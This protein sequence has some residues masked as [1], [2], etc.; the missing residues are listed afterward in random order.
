MKKP[1]TLK[2]VLAVLLC[3]Q[4]FVIHA[5]KDFTPRFDTSLK[6]DML[7]IGNNIL[8]RDNNKANE[9]PND[10]Y[11]VY[12]QNNNNLQMYYVDID[13][14]SSTFSSSSATLS[15]PS[16]SRE[17]YKIV[18]AGLYWAG[19]YSQGSIDN[20][21]VNRSNLGSIKI[22]LPNQ[23]AYTDISGQ[24]IYDY[25]PSNSNGSQI[26]YAYYYDLTSLVQG[27]ANPEGQYTVANIISAQGNINGGFSAGWNLFVVYEDPKSSAKYI[28]SFDGFRWIQANSNAVT[29]NISGFKTIPTGTVKAKLAFAALEGDVDLTGDR[30][31]INNTDIS[32]AERPVDNFFNSTIND[33][34]GPFTNRNLASGNTLGFEAGILNVPNPANRQNPGGS[35]IKNNDTSATL[36]LTTSGDGYGLFFNAFNVEI[37]EPKIVLTKIVKN[38]QGVNIGGQNVTLGQQLNYEIGFKNT[39]NDNA[40]SFTIRDQLP[41]NIIFNYPAD[42]VSLPSGVTVQSYNAATRNIVFKVDNNVVKVG[43][44]EK[45]ISFKVQVVPDCHM[46]SEACSNSIDNSAYAT[47][48]GTQNTAF[49]ISDDPSVNTNTGC[50]LIP[51]AT[52]FLVGVDGCKYTDNVTLCGESINLTAANGYTDYTWYS[53]EARTQLIGKGQTLNVK[54]P[55]TY[56]VYNLAAAPCRS[57]YQ[58]FVVT[59]F[60]STVENPVIPFADQVV[61]CSND[62][63]KLPNIFLCGG[64]ASRA[65]TLNISDANSIVWEKLNESSCTAVTNQ[66]CANESTS[67]TWTT[68]KTGSTYNANQAGQFRL[69]LNYAG[70]CFNRFYFNVYSNSLT[71]TETHKDIICGAPGSITIGGVP[72]GYEYAISTDPNGTPGAY[73][74]SNIFPI[75]SPNSYTVHIRQIG[76]TT[77]PCIFTVPGILIR[78]RDLS[79][80]TTVTQP[81][82]KNDK[83]SIKVGAQNIDPQ[84]YY[85][86][87]TSG[88]TL[89][90]SFGPTLNSDYTFA[91]LSSGD[92]RV[93]VTNGAVGSTPAPSCDKTVDVTIN[94]VPAGLNPTAALT[95]PLTAC[96]NGKIVV[97]TTGGTA[98]YYHFINGSS[99]FQLSN[100]I[101]VTGPGTYDIR[102]VDAN[103]CSGTTSITVN[104]NPKPTYTVTAT[105]INCSG[106]TSQINV[107]VTNANGYTLQYSIDNGAT[108]SNNPVFPNVTAGTYNVVVRY[109]MSGVTCTDPATPIT[110]TQP[111]NALSASA[112]VSELAGC[113]PSG[114]GF[115]KVRITNPQGGT[116]PYTYSFDGGANY[117]T[118]NEAYV[119]PGTYTLYIKDSKGCIYSMPGVILDPK[120]A[121]PTISIAPPVFNCNGTATS[122]VTVTSGGGTNYAYQY[123]LDNVLNTNTPSNVFVNVPSGSHTISVKYNLTS[124]PTY[125]NLLIEDFGSGG[126]TTAP[127]IASAYCFNDQRV[128]PPYTCSLNGTPTRSVEDN[129]YSVTSFFWRNDT[130]WYHFKDHTS[131][132]A[133]ANGRYLLV[134]IGSAAGP[135]GILYSKPIIDVIPN[136]P[137]MVDL[138]VANLLNTGVSGAAPIVRFELV[139][140]AGQVVA[141]QDTGKIAEAANDPNRTKWVPINISLNPGNNTN[142]TFRIRSGSTD[143]AGN[144]I[145]IDDIWVRQIPKSCITQKDFPIVIDSNKAFSASITGFKNLTCAGSNNGEITIATQNFNLPYGFDYSLDNGTTW[146]NSKVSPVTA[147]GLTNKTYSI[148][149]R[150]DSSASSCTFPFSQVITAPAA[151][152]V[153]ARVTAQP[154][155]S[156]GASITATVTG[157]TPSYQYELRGSNGTTVVVPFQASNVFTNVATG[158]Y[159][160]VVKDTNACTSPASATVNISSPTV[161]TAT[162]AASSDLCYD[163]TNQSTLVVTATGTGTLTYS[164]DGGAAQTSNTFTNVGPG[165]HNVVVTDSNNCTATVSNIVIAPELQATAA[166]TKVVDCTSS[167]NA[168]I[169]VTITGGTSAF[170]YKVKRTGNYGSSNNVT[171]NSFVYTATNTGTYTFEI[172]DSKG[173][174]TTTSAT[175]NAR[176]NPTVTATKVDATCNGASTGSVELTGSGGSG[177]YTYLFYNSTTTPVPTTYT[178]QT[179]YTGLAAGTYNYRVMDSGT[180]TSA[181]GSITINQPTTLTATASATAFSC[182]TSNVK[183]SAT[184]T[185][186]VP[187]TGTSPYQYSFD[188]GT[189]FTSTRTLTVT[190]NGTNQTISYVVSDAQGCKTP[191]QTITINRLNPPTD[192]TFSSNAVTCTATTTTVTAT[193]TNGVGTLTYAITSPAASVAT[194]TTGV[195]SG[196]AAGTYNFRVTDANGCYFEKPYTINAV[197]PIAVIGN[198]T[199]DALC[200][201]GATG[202]GTYT[203]SGNAAVGAYTFTLTAGTLG[204]G[205]LTK[206]GNTLTLS[207]V[208]AGTYTVQVTDTA[209][210][211]TNTASIVI[212]EPANA[213]TFT[214]AASNV[215]CNND[216]SQITV[217]A[218]GG[219]P[220][221]TYAAVKSGAAAPTVYDASNVV[222]VDTNSGA[223]LVWDVYVKDT[224]GCIA[225]N[226]VTVAQDNLPTVTA[227]N[228]NQC[229]ASGNSF[230]ITATG[231]GLAPLM[232]SIDG[233]SFQSSNTFN[234]PAGTYT[235]TVRDKNNC[236][237][238]TATALTIYPQLTAVG[239]VTKELDCTT[240]PNATITVT[241]G[242]GKSQFTYTVQK[243]SGAPSTA[244]APISGPT[245]TY[246]VTPAN[247]DTYT[248]VVTDANGCQKTAVVTVDPISNPTVTAIQTDASCNGASDGSVTLTGAGGSGGFTYS[249][250]AATGFTANPTFTGLAAGN[251]TFYVRDSKGCQGSVA[252][253]ITQPTTLAATIATVPF[254]CN[255]SNGKVAGTVT[256]NVTAGTGTAPYEYSFNGSGY[257]SNNVLTLNDNGADQP[258]TYAV[259]DAKGCPVTGSGTLLRLNPPTDLTFASPAVTCTATTTTV[260]LAAVNGVGVLQYETI[261][262]SAVI[263]PKQTSNSFA[264]L[265]PGTYMFKVTDANGCYYTESYT[266]KP[267]T[268][269]TVIGNKTSDAL[270]KGG[271]TG[272]GIYTVSGNAAVGAYTFTLTAGTLGSGTLTKSGNTLTLSNVAAGTYTVQVT[273]TATGCTNTASIV[274][275][276]PANAV[277]FTAAASNVNCNN[278]NS[279]ITVTAAGGTP[280]YTYAA[281]KSGAA[282]PTVYDAS[283]VVTVDTNSGADLVWDVYVKDTNGCI[284]KNTVTVAQDNLPTVTAT[285][286]NQ[287]TASG[288]SFTITATGTGLAPLMYSIDGTSFQSSNTFNVPAGTYTV[289]VRDKNNC[290]ATTATALTIYPQLTAVGAVTK[291][292]DCTTTP[293]ATITVTIGGGK[294]QFTYT[295]QKGSGA[296]STASAPISGPTFTY[297]VTPANADTYTFV[298][299]DANGCQ[300]TAVVTVD[301]IS[302]PTVTAI[303]TDASCNGASD[304]SVTLT[305]AGG[306]GGFTYSNNAATGFTAN[307]TFTGLAAGNYTFYVRDSKG[308]QGSVAVTITQPT[309]L[310]ATIATVPFSCNAS[311]GKV[312]GTVTINVTAGTGTAPYEYSFN[313]SGYSSNNVL[314]LNDNGAD[315]PYTYAVRDAKGCPVTGSGTLLRLNPPTDLTFASPAV[316]CTATTTTVTLTAVNGVGTLQYET[317]APSAVIIPKQTS[318][319]F[320]NLAPGTYMFKVTDANGCY[321][322]ESY[323]VK[324]VTPITLTANK[325]SDVLCNGGNTGSIRLNV[326]GFGSTYS[327]TVNGGTAITGVNTAT[328][329]LPNLTAGTYAI[330]VTDEVTGCT[331]PASITINQP[332]AAL[333][334][335]YTTVNAN[336]F[337]GTSEVT[338]TA[339][340]GT[341]VY[342][343]SFVQDGAAVG[344]YSNNNKA[345]LDPAVSLNWDVYIIDANNCT[346]KLDVTIARDAVPTVTASATGQCFGVGSYTITA[347]PG[348]GLVAPLSYSI[349][350]GASYQAGNTFVITTPGN[351]T[352]R[353]KDGNGCTANSNVVVVDNILGLTAV[354][355]KDVT[356]STAT[357]A[358]ITLTAN[359]GRAP[360]TYESKEAAGAYTAMASNVFNTMT[361]GNYTFR[362]TDANGCNFVTT[363]PVAITTPVL[364]EITGVTQTQS[365]N[366]NGDA[367]AAIAITID[368][369]KG[370][371]PFVFTVLNT[372]TG[373]NYGSQTSGLAAGNYVVT[374]TDA[375][376]CTDTFNITIAQPIPIVVTRTVTPITCGAGGVSLGSITINSVSG[377]TPNYTYHVTGVNG[378][379]KQ[380]SNQTGATA[381]FEVVDFGL[382]QIIITDANG[383][384]NIEQNVFV[385]SPPDDL[386]ITVTSPPADCSS[387]GSAVVAIGA[388]STNITGNG[389]F[390]FAVYTGTG[391]TYTAPT[392]L[393]WYDEDVQGSPLG[394]NPGSKKTT[395]PNLLPGVKYTFVVHDAGTGCYYYE[396]ATMPIPT[397]STL[398][399]TGLTSNNITCRGSNDGNVSLTVNSTYPI[400]TPISYEI[401][402]SFTM[403]STGI[404]GT[405]TVPAN[406]NLVINNLGALSFGNYVVVI[407]ETAGATNAGCSVASNSFNITQSAI[408]LSV[409]ASVSK[410]ANCN[411]NSGIITAVAKDGTAPYTYL[412][413]PSTDPVPTAS[414]AGWASANTFNRNAGSYIAYAKDAYGCIKSAAVTLNKDADPTITAPAE[415]CYDGNP[416]TISIGGTVDPAIV[417]AANYSVNGSAFQASPDFTYNAPGT[418]TLVIKDGN[419]CTATTTYEVKPQLLLSVELTKELNCTLTPDAEITLT[420]TGGYSSSY[421]YEYSTN[422]GGSYTT[423]ASN[424][425]T[426]SVLGN[427]IFRVSD[428]KLPAACQATATFTLDPLPNTVFTTAQTDVSCN[429]GTDGT[430]T[431]NV[432]SGVGPYEYQLDGGAFQ[433]SNVFTGLSAGNSYII[434]VRD[435]KSCLFPSTAITINEPAAL[436][437]TSAITTA[438]VCNTGNVPSKAVVTV[439]GV[440]GT[441]PYLYSF[442]NGT[443]YTSANTFETYVGTTFNVLVKD[444]KGCIYTLVNGVNVP[445]LDPPTI[446]T[447]I[448]TPVYCAPAA[449]TSSTVTVTATNGV[450]ALA[451]AILSP[452]S[453]TGNVSGAASGIFTSLAPATYLFEVTDS[454]GCKD[455]KSYTVDPVT[456][457]TIAGQ[458]VSNVVCNGQANGAVKFTVANYGTSYTA[459]LTAGTGT[460]VQTGNTVDV[461]GLVPGAYT[462]T[463]TDDTTGCTATAS[464][465]VAQPTALALNLVS[466]VNANCNFGAKVSVSAA[467]GTPVYRY[468]FVQDGATPNPLDYDTMANAVLDPTVNTQWDAYVIDANGCETKLDITIDTDPLPTINSSAGLYCYTG[469]PVPI[470][471]TGT[472]VAPLMYSIG[473][474]YQSSP[475][476]VLNAPGNYKFYIKDAN[477]CIV[478]SPYTLRQELLLQ[479]TLTQD[480]TCAG[481]ATITFLA[482]Q[483]TLTYASYEVDYNGGGYFPA[484]SPY[485][486]TAAGTYT[487][488][489]IDSQG[490]QAVSNTIVVTPTTTP[491]ATFTQTN[492]SCIGGSDGSIIVTAANGILPYQYRINGGTF[493]SSNIFTGL[494]AGTYNIEVR[495]AKQCTS[496]ILTATIT[497]PSALAATAVLT[498]SLT[499]GT[500]N[501]T[502]PA[503]VTVNVTAGT[504]TAPYQYS[505]NGGTNY[506]ATNTFTTYN[507]G[508]VTAYVKDANNCIIAVPVD[509]IVPAL[510]PPT[511]MDITGT[512]VYCAPA[513]R[514]TSTVTINSV[515][516]GVGTL[517]YEILSPIAVAKQNSNVFA[518][519]TPD[520]YLFQVTDANGCTY[521][522]S[523]TVDPVTNITIAGQLV[524]N[525]VCNGQSN[526]AVKFT[527]ANYGTSYTA[528]L[529]A[530]TG[531]LVQTGNT[532]DVTGLVPGTYTVTVT[533]DTTG[534]TAS[535]SVTVAQPT[536]LA[537]NLVSNVN[538]NCNFGAKVSV[539]AAGGTPVYRYQFVQDGATPNPLDYDTMANAVLDPTVNTQWDAYVIDANGCETKLDI[540]IDTDPLPTINSSAGLYCYTGGPVPITITGTGVA[541]LMYSIGNGYQSSPN[542]VLNAPGNYKFYIKDANG[543]IVESPYTLRQELLLQA[544]LTQDLT[545]AGSATITFLATQGTLTYASYEVD[546]NGGGYFPATSPYTATAAGTYT[547]RVIDSQGCQAVSNTIVVTPTTTPTATFTQTNVS[548]IGGSDGSIIVT[549]ANGILPYQYRI[550]GGTFQSSNIFTGLA[551]G[552]YNIEVRDAKQCT[553]V[554]VTATITEPSALAATAV[555][556]QS[557]TCGTGNA[558]QPA[559]VTVNVTA[560]TGTA[561]YQYSFNGGAN[562]SATNTFTTY[563]SGTVTAYVKDANNCIIAAPVDVIVPALNPP[564]IS[565]INGTDIYCAPTANTTS[566]VTVNVTNGVGPLHFEILSPASATTNTSGATSGVFTLLDAGTYLFQVTDANGCKDEEYYTVKPLVNITIAGQLVNDVS[567]NGGANGSVK[568]DVNNFSGTYTAALIGGPTTGTITQVGKVV[569]LTNLPIGNYTIEV[570]DQITNCKASAS[571]TVG[572][573]SV[574]TL[575]ETVNVHANCNSGAKVSVTA[576]GG[577]PNYR[578]AFIAGTGTPTATD[579]SNSNNAVLDPAVNTAWRAYVID[580][581]NCETFIPITI[582]MD[583]LPS[584]ITANVTSQCP[585]AAGEYTFTVSVGSGVAPYEYSIGSGFQSSPTFTVNKAGTYD[586]TVRDA[587]ACTATATAAVTISP[588]LQLNTVVNALPSCTLNN[589]VITATASG[590][591]A[592]ANYRYTLDGGVIVNTTP[593]V[594]NNVAPGTHIV[595]VRDV[596]TGCAFQVTVEIAPATVIT[597]F[598]LQGTNVSCKGGSDASITATLDPSSVGVND[599]PV[600]TYTLTGTTALGVAV[601]RPAQ[602]LN[603]FENLQAGDYTVTV[604]SG[605]GCQDSEDIRIIENPV[606]TVA[607]PII[608]QYG[609][610]TGTNTSA[611]ATITVSAVTGG[612]GNYVSYEFL[613]NGVVVQKGAENVYTEADFLGGSYTVNVYDDNGCM[614]TTAATSVI[615]PFISLDAVNVNVDTAVTCISNEDITVTVTSTGG[616]PVLLN[617]IVTGTNG[618]TYSQT[619]TSGV[620]TGLTI[621]E[622]LITVNNPATG[623]SIQ[624]VHYVNNPNTFDIKAVT[625]NGQICYGAANG[626]V[627]LTFV[628]NQ[629]NPTNDAGAFNYVITGPVPSNGTATNAGPIRISNLTAG[630][631][632]VTATLVNNPFCTVTTLFTIEQPAVELQLTTT[633][634][635]I[636][637]ATGNNDGEISASATGGWDNKYEYQLVL[638]GTILVDYSQ[639]SVFAG[640]SAGTYTINVRDN[641]GC[642]DTATE[643]LAIPS[644][645]T[646]TATPSA[647][648]LSCFGDKTATITVSVPTGGQGSNYMYTLNTVIGTQTISSGPQSSNIFDGL[649]AG[650][651]SIKVTDGFNCEATS[652][653]IVIT[654]PAEVIPNLIL[655]SS[656]T[657]NVQSTLTLGATGGVG[658]YSYSTD[659]NFA[660]NLGTFNSSVTFSVPVGTYQYYVRDTNNCVSFV[661]NE[662]KIDPLVPLTVDLDITNAIVKCTGEA[663]GVI[664][665][666]AKG[667]LGNYSYTLQ[668]AAG[669][670]IQGPQSNGRFENLLIGTYKVKVDSGDCSSTSVNAVITE[671]AAALIATFT[672]TNVSC[673]GENNGK[674]VITA[675][676]GTGV[677]KY[678][679]SPDLNQFDFITTFDRLAPGTYTVIAQDENGCYVRQDVEITQPNPVIVTEVPNS[680][681]PEV[682][683]GDK[684]GAF[685]IEVKG[686]T[687][688][689][690]VSLDNEKGPFTQG[691]ATQ[692][693]FD[694]T[695]LAGGTHTVYVKDAE[696]CIIEFVENMPNAVI[697]NPTAEVT[698]DCVNNTQA[699]MVVVTIDAS[700]TNPADVDYSLDNNGVFQPSNIFTNVPAGDHFIVARHTNG[701]EV[702]TPIFTVNA[703]AELGLIDIT[704]QSKDINTIV[705]QASGGVAPY[706]YSFNGEPFSSSNSY[707]IYKTGDYVVIVRDKNGCEKTITVHGTFYDFC[708]PNYFTPNGDG[709]NDTIGPDCGA[710]AYK[711][712]TFDIYDRYGRVVAKYRVNGKWDGRYHGDE[713][714]T[715][716]YW[717]VL[718]LNDPKD[719]R[720][721]VGHFTLYR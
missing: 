376:G 519:L 719:P 176:T 41:I 65:I 108:F 200:K 469:G 95:V 84:Y 366:C 543:C 613:K 718:K 249:N 227:T 178:T 460:L 324:P 313:G 399:V 621:G 679:I 708:M 148:R 209:T 196:L 283:N 185:I 247:A 28:T 39:G 574:L 636:T 426:T 318:N 284:A 4:S 89:V 633:K 165:T 329:T 526:G 345:N 383:C 134:N 123:Y 140:S 198:K 418:Y 175:I 92:Y 593:A 99:T 463:V 620:F 690:S 429:S 285:N 435:A 46:L 93:R 306:S 521:Q 480:L 293:N 420:A 592:T 291:E 555:L 552:T 387:L 527:V 580:S 656:Q 299:T 115:G 68:V 210:G 3:I 130:A 470:T 583:P 119:A 653:S 532:V 517:Q 627:D 344:T 311:N 487:F 500:G 505:F 180:C 17:C 323:T 588:A 117:G 713:L 550:N 658:P 120:P 486:A 125:S 565:T 335:T 503:I 492:V 444:A 248:F 438:L 359:G 343:Y 409:T 86:I 338:V 533:D 132:G 430:I 63:K 638:N 491:T 43:D 129:Q 47:Y 388:S 606:I 611:Y 472:G 208:A 478:E 37:I 432:T 62:G 655:A 670:P 568:F 437:A 229:T 91:N 9:R 710:L 339:T 556:T 511:D 199:S 616:T 686:G 405:G 596:V 441:S 353:I 608:A 666:E 365:I 378:Y 501:A 266:V 104:A 194:N 400:A 193:A 333:A 155:C 189:T 448:G 116:P 630:Q 114:N 715:G 364:P 443:T 147:T 691:T 276:E 61:T 695:N 585:T 96:S 300:K 167:P 721:F 367:T 124:V 496:V 675:S 272:S 664:V 42:I 309:T 203:V 640:L 578:Y 80:S 462:V 610:A 468:Q 255:A 431:V 234:V 111:A 2:L 417:G 31:S 516:N 1:T 23:A 275:G 577:T 529:T 673:F 453:A 676:G 245:F 212:G 81:T 310:A 107:N 386:D 195:F 545:C 458:L 260:T 424:V 75:T 87:Y 566:T 166:V 493:Q 587:N 464:V 639:Q 632:T 485:T 569:T 456:N 54:N 504:G 73:Q 433:A 270:C 508:T 288:N 321:Y 351:Y 271:A 16:G 705:V 228:G 434:T 497:E 449:N 683:D 29:Y 384:T 174:I 614:G 256:I 659:P 182:S 45:V 442:D 459:A 598:A 506:S 537:L 502:Q 205:T 225:K 398:T 646:F 352:I 332:V 604:T 439:T 20:K 488:R 259:R 72:A 297:S 603:V 170:T 85:Y 512:P 217:T 173:C 584:G 277:T 192:I 113:D 557:L 390:H 32:T 509:V 67:C 133:D 455:Q 707:R 362:V 360:Y 226:T 575:T 582:V 110:I 373:T 714:P 206:S 471:I 393:P 74:T 243:G 197:T 697:L 425:L 118:S 454:N 278:D 76:V 191:V 301:P 558:T 348:T 591:S 316:T 355:N 530:G 484:T 356:C 403:V 602:T 36:K 287:C 544:T 22:K 689:Y 649:G 523:Y 128:N 682:C 48:K 334:A 612:S 394:V 79:I 292:L 274:I 681:I 401:Y 379:N 136:Q 298:V 619:N 660:T 440:D 121:D 279:Q 414:T 641:V 648:L 294:S 473:N 53:D 233:T 559:I 499:C 289:T 258:Y 216:N 241:I 436:S 447:I 169:T 481:S 105:E 346:F 461:T 622:Y 239:A 644:P 475:N 71:P 342:R 597:G 280:N 237:A 701:C 446:T 94:P 188:G 716:D 213:V 157:G 571:V 224:N 538:A 5:Q 146:V 319:S 631:Y 254:S 15:I 528:A 451:Y 82:C 494:A 368:N 623:C 542:F 581:N 163:S 466:N 303:Q 717:Y 421:T 183:Q 218:A 269:I 69:T 375:K 397:N 586:I 201:G 579:Y 184:I 98:P 290:T 513:A 160:V 669:N 688:P 265:A 411:A 589:G 349:N 601:N 634:L 510:N 570:T 531:T 102:V 573:P 267:V 595:R 214:A 415:I 561:P 21:T 141:T 314:T 629:L 392:A 164:L 322:T 642:I 151:L 347:T 296:P 25:Y 382:Y 395:I 650:T 88:G 541:P 179:S 144:D 694:F 628:D 238:T 253:T 150:F 482:T 370:Q 635:A 186:A 171:G 142:L 617:Y 295:V 127:G 514:T 413:L 143:Y 34:N 685:S 479:A 540:T 677:I 607:A 703:V 315:Q 369:T 626:S 358:Q 83:G 103:N 219:T 18:Y 651:Y 534:C 407:K 244:S 273:D 665:A 236:T 560:G 652:A 547:F 168:Q 687:L 78:S 498:Q 637:C 693:I 109:T 385:A 59:R 137:V 131:N 410:N 152:A 445:V 657:C 38:A 698:Y 702:P 625:V 30:Y 483:G 262:P 50:I 317:I 19:I 40:T 515:T 474:G 138:Y 450:G 139:N 246:S 668:D 70:G 490:C 6:G 10:A 101:A 381:V 522:E 377:G 340:G 154:T 551:A 77:N 251:Y 391:M 536:A 457:I 112:G 55:G 336:C 416:F 564:T 261:A 363:V 159:T 546:Y 172:T 396:T 341:P 26:P 600:Y 44:P 204:S 257:S 308:C 678:A 389:P 97:T 187:T 680:M 56:Y 33:T 647:T 57:I 326:A 374:V 221:Y 477:G 122:T 696:G 281:V 704:N 406:G 467:G 202:S 181:I 242:G 177:T 331:A 539:S 567:C 553:S 211:C 572:Q 12:N 548:C 599:N 325:L 489:V 590:G 223:D 428:A 240:T 100:E 408:D 14:D 402:D 153:T 615:T 64:N 711:E 145:V 232:Y 106:G 412:L 35:V 661:S 663:T 11:N 549:A 7:L 263:I 126:T 252:V 692:T 268:P 524:S 231:T 476:F 60:G 709:Q 90:N 605:R 700:I 720:E 250:N 423:M 230:T 465:T 302:N 674:I 712:L 684:D 361:P 305:G 328:V 149:V 562:Y 654:E 624:S 618:N 645:I 452:A 162:L 350:N 354:L 372:T 427:Y 307:P 8:N 671:P 520:T 264:N 51:K 27:L 330:V 371:A 507:S 404:T 337:V 535:A 706:E 304:G 327:Y 594:F 554:I 643:V 576:A 286:G 699:N 58:S 156:N 672:P 235:V 158:T 24:L 220:N 609:C 161:P 662:I 525:V 667:G 222:T 563:N 66:N 52:N 215:N 135:Y 312:A 495:D 190:D 320:A 357:A 207:N 49:T 518:G 282:A 419:G 13:N 380:I 422:G